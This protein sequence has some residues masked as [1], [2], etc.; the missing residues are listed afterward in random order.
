[1]KGY[2]REILIKYPITCLDPNVNFGGFSAIGTEKLRF[3]KEKKGELMF[4]IITPVRLSVDMK[5]GGATIRGERIN[6]CLNEID[7][8][9]GSNPVGF[10]R[11]NV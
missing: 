5:L 8:V 7:W 4:S 3:I 11:A 6:F 2:L 1:L 9:E 10:D